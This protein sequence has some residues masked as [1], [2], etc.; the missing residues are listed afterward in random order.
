VYAQRR[1]AA[2]DMIRAGAMI[3]LLAIIIIPFAVIQLGGLLGTK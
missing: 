1:F 2:K 3:N